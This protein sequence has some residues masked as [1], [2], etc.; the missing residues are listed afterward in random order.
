MSCTLE[1]TVRNVWC[2]LWGHPGLRFLA[3]VYFR[4]FT[5]SGL[6]KHSLTDGENQEN[7]ER[8]RYSTTHTTLPRAFCHF[9]CLKSHFISGK[10]IGLTE[11][12]KTFSHY[13][14]KLLLCTIDLLHTHAI[15]VF[16][17]CMCL[18]LTCYACAGNSAHLPS[19][20]I[21]LEAQVWSECLMYGREW[22]PDA[23]NYNF[24]DSNWTCDACN[25]NKQ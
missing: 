10:R 14:R 13:S 21:I 1:C 7:G 16:K 4:A 24:V 17:G 19:L 12:L 9:I 3:T 23:P 20:Y 11:H 22:I 6:Q 2:S 5:C 15:V 18:L 8:S 25:T